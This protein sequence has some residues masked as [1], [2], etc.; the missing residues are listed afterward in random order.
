MRILILTNSDEGLYRFRREL[1]EKLIAANNDVFVS[2]FNG[3]YV[4]KIKAIGCKYIETKF[5]RK[6]TN[7]ISDLKLLKKYLNIINE[8]KPDIV[9]TYT[10]KPNVYGGLACQIKKIPYICTI[11]GLGSAIENG[12][13]LQKISLTLYKI[14][15]KKVNT[16]FFQNETNMHYFI[17]N[18]VVKEEHSQLVSGS[19]V[20]LKQYKL[21]DFPND[22][23]IDFAYIGRVM[24]EKGFEQYV[25]AAKEI[26]NKYPNTR[27]HVSGMYEDN[28]KD[29]IEELVKNNIVI[30]HG[31]IED[32]INEIYKII[33]C[34]I[35]P[36]YYAEGMS[37]VLLESCASGRAI[38]TTNRP[39]CKEVLDDGVNGYFVKEKDSND[40]ISKIEK[41][42]SLSNCE[43]KEMGLQGR[44]KVESN[45][46]R[47]N[48]I[49]AYIGE[50]YKYGK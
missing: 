17:D 47:N 33:Q 11:T 39:G 15:L 16:V 34:T 1:L 45:F 2:I 36:T 29:T 48:V 50:I 10:I 41:F 25:E 19:G 6:G 42:I 21:L 3:K 38:I 35:H 18:G 40:L 24:K 32:M 43:R 26:R 30:Y 9:L 8:V 44:K 22:N 14:G 7:P 12:G 5:N 46:D 13:L 37:N 23:T 4:E 28:Y 31:N 20:N 27:F 49:K